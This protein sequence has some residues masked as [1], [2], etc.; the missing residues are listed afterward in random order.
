MLSEHCPHGNV[1]PVAVVERLSDWQGRSGR[2]KCAICAYQEGF[3]AGIM[4]GARQAR[5]DAAHIAPL[6]RR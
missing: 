4:K 3:E 6:D 1:A 2:H 5:D